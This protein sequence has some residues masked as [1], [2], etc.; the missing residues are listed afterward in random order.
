MT[1]VERIKN[2]H[3]QLTDADFAQNIVVQNDG[4]GRGDYLAEW[5]HPAIPRPTDEQLKGN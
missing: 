2:A 5:N 1:L 4:D 3:P